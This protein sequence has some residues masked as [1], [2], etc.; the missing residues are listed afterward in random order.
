MLVERLAYLA[1]ILLR[2]YVLNKENNIRSL[3]CC[4]R[5]WA[6]E[7]SFLEGCVPMKGRQEEVIFCRGRMAGHWKAGW[8]VF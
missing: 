1:L 2:F 6:R 4:F 8:H 7:P 3:Q 5:C